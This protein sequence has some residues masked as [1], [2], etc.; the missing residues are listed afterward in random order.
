MV[1]KIVN[2]QD[3]Y[4][5]LNQSQ[6]KNNSLDKMVEQFTSVEVQAYSAAQYNTI[7]SLNTK[8][9]E[10]NKQLEVLTEKNKQLNKDLAVAGLNEP[11]DKSQFSVS[12]EEATCTIQIALIKCNAMDRELTTDEVKRLEI[13][14]KTLQIIKGRDIKEDK[15]KEEKELAKMSSSELLAYADKSFKDPQ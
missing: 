11:K 6:Q 4:Q 12:D 3:A 13:F 2:A 10:L 5:H 14:V 9:N 8:I 15:S 7:L 1:K